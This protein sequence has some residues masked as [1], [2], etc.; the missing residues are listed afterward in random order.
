MPKVSFTVIKCYRNSIFKIWF[1]GFGMFELACPVL[2]THP[3]ENLWDKVDRLLV[4]TKF[5]SGNEL[6]VAINQIWI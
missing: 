2:Q 4:G 6:F 5:S 1:S 3:I